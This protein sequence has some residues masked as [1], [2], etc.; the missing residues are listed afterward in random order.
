MGAWDYELAKELRNLG[1]RKERP[2]ILEGTV[3][4]VSPLTVSLYGGEVM[5]PPAPLEAL[6]C[7]Q[8]FYRNEHTGHLELET[9]KAGDRVCC[10]WMGKTVVVLGRL[11][12]PAETLDE[13]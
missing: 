11:A 5:A 9:W 1:Q 6:F 8:G 13:R 7:A 2:E 3:V 12:D 10:C 4:S